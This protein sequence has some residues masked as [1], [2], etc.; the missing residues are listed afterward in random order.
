[1]CYSGATVFSRFI[2]KDKIYVLG[3]VF[4]KKMFPKVGIVLKKKVILDLSEQ[5]ASSKCI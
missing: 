2:F 5:P 4:W 3:P 1:M